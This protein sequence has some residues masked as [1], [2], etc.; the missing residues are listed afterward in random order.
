MKD[1]SFAEVLIQVIN[2][3]RR[4][5]R[6]ALV[7]SELRSA[8]LRAETQIAVDGQLEKLQSEFVSKGEIGCWKSH[9]NAMRKLVETKAKFSLILEDDA[10]PTDQATLVAD[11]IRVIGYLSKSTNPDPKV[12]CD[13]S[14]SFSTAQL[15]VNLSRT[16]VFQAGHQLLFSA[17]APFTNTL[18]AVLMSGSFTA[19]L[20]ESVSRHL[21][22]SADGYLPIDWLVNKYFLSSQT[23]EPTYGSF[24]KLLPGLYRQKSLE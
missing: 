13:L 19:D 14:Q 23:K 3:E 16:H 9:I 7:S 24:F 20:S 8:G 10:S 6:L 5:D 11:L 17:P 21:D 22:S 18:C 2:L 1:S 15:G 4:P 12:Y